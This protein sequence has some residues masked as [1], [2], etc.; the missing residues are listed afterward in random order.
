M[1]E[2]IVRKIPLKRITS[3]EEYEKNQKDLQYYLDEHRWYT[4]HDSEEA[5]LKDIDKRLDEYREKLGETPKDSE[6]RKQIEHELHALKVKYLRVKDGTYDSVLRNNIKAEM[7]MLDEYDTQLHKIPF[8]Q[9]VK[10][11]ITGDKKVREYA[12]KKLV[13][14]F[15]NSFGMVE[16]PYDLRLEPNPTSSFAKDFQDSFVETDTAELDQPQ[17][18]KGSGYV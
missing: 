18:E 5:R 12:R 15:N 3:V 9:V 6:E 2:T 10:G 13:F 16:K 8:G 7:I 14:T 1:A 11:I 4:S 17:E